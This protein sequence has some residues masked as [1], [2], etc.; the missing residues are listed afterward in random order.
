MCMTLT[1]KCCLFLRRKSAQ[2]S[3]IIDVHKQQENSLA[4][5]NLPHDILSTPLAEVRSSP[6]HS[7]NACGCVDNVSSGID[8][9]SCISDTH[10]DHHGHM[11]HSCLSD[12][13]DGIITSSNRPSSE[14]SKCFVENLQMLPNSY[15]AKLCSVFQVKLP[16]AKIDKTSADKCSGPST[17]SKQS[18]N[19]DLT[20]MDNNMSNRHDVTGS[21]GLLAAVTPIT[22]S[23]IETGQFIKGEVNSHVTEGCVQIKNVDKYNKKVLGQPVS[24]WNEMSVKICGNLITSPP[25]SLASSFTW[26]AITTSSSN[27]ARSQYQDKQTEQNVLLPMISVSTHDDDN[28]A[29]GPIRGTHPATVMK[30]MPWITKSSQDKT[31]E[32]SQFLR[33]HISS[34]DLARYQKVD[35]DEFFLGN[36][37]FSNV[38]NSSKICRSISVSKSLFAQNLK[39]SRSERSFR[40]SSSD[41]LLSD[42]DSGVVCMF[43]ESEKIISHMIPLNQSLGASNIMQ[44]SLT[45]GSVKKLQRMQD[46]LY[47]LIQQKLKSVR[48]QT[49]IIIL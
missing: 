37:W 29:S 38:Q 22:S 42:V 10:R 14:P 8:L 45:K 46:L 24:E 26:T 7:S 18:S 5:I 33:K 2:H 15:L 41:N 23:T 34:Q 25:T 3:R 6:S 43:S 11:S 48:C 1:Q 21:A 32:M 16:G 12:S 31:Y 13:K 27:T 4:T 40:M 20:S 35:V 47:R 9:S 39:T 30:W 28:H 49:H 44:S 36:N 17:I 19:S